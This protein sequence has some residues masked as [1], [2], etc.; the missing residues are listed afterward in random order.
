[1][2]SCGTNNITVTSD[3]ITPVES[4]TDLHHSIRIRDGLPCVFAGTKSSQRKTD[5]SFFNASSSFTQFL[6][7]ST[8]VSL[9]SRRGRCGD[10]FRYIFTVSNKAVQKYNMSNSSFHNQHIIHIVDY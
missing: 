6:L 9:S 8:E 3:G 4:E 7:I 10:E 1:M 2:A 5:S